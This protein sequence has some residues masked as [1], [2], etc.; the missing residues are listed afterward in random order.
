[1]KKHFKK[2]ICLALA[3]MLIFSVTACGAEKKTPYQGDVLNGRRQ[4]VT[5]TDTWFVKPGGTTDYA[6]LLPSSYGASHVYAAEEIRLRVYESTGV[7]L[8]IVKEAV[9]DIG[10]NTKFISIGATSIA[11]ESGITYTKDELTRNGF[12]I[13]SYKDA[14]L[15]LSPTYSGYV[16]GAYRF[17][18]KQIDYV[19]YAPTEVRVGDYARSGVKLKNFNFEDWPD[20]LNRVV[21]NYDTNSDSENAMRLYNNPSSYA[22]S[23]DSKYG[24][25][26]WWSSL[27][28]QSMALQ[29]LPYGTYRDAHSEWYVGG[30]GGSNA[31]NP[32]ICYTK[33]LY[34]RDDDDLASNYTD[35]SWLDDSDFATAD[36][37]HGMFW[38]FCYNLINNYIKVETDKS[39]FQLG[40][41]DNYSFCNCTKC[42][43]DV[44]DYRRSGIA[45]R[46]ANAVADVVEQWRLDHCP[47]REIYLTMFAYLTI[48]EPPVD[49]TIDA[50]GKE[51][52]T[53][54]DPS[55]IVRDNI[56]VR[57]APIGDYYLYPLIDKENNAGAYEAINGWAA[58]AKN[59]A[60]W[61]YRI[62]FAE[63]LAP[64]PQWMSNYE[65]IKTY[66]DYGYIDVFHQGCRTFGNTPF[67]TVDNYV[68]SR[69]LWNVHEDYE[70]LMHEAI[71]AY[72][73]DA[74]PLMEEYLEY[75]TLHYMNYMNKEDGWKAHSHQ[76]YI[77]THNFPRGYMLNVEEIFSRAYAAIEPT[78]A[79]NPERYEKIKFRVD[80]ESVPY[81]Y[82]QLRLYSKYYTSTERTEMID[83]FERIVTGA[84]ILG[85]DTFGGMEDIIAGFRQL[86]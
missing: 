41:S 36:A 57:Y 12:K 17:L 70:D 71:C 11:N 49:K 6:I 25:G 23:A 62:N 51:V 67:V 72:Y 20:I 10:D 80:V 60:V 79:T 78:K 46:F 65:N 16:Y 54:V 81:R 15:I 19:Y 50:T 61:D 3:V 13:M 69:L 68:R 32:N 2:L 37:P 52:W 35:W 40:M 8:E 45:F 58:V 7:N 30:A 75:T 83:E 34:S 5:E 39:F 53:A 38:T 4:S 48:V 1:M 33:A 9:T 73:D 22:L 63:M 14:V 27:H 82:L 28:D 55:V 77:T 59:F 29:I 24:E 18:E 21:F 64:F 85:L 66:Y 43:E 47:D 56:V 86:V 44:E 76:S 31:T 74:A 42:V 26:S 84:R